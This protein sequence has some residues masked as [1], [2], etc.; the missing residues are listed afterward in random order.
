MKS[1]I[2]KLFLLIIAIGLL[3][4]GIDYLRITSGDIPIFNYSS[5]NE[6]NRIQTYYGLLYKAQRKITISE[7]EPLIN[8]NNIKFMLI[9]YKTLDVPKK[10]KNVEMEYT[11]K[12]TPIINCNEQSKLYY[13][14]KEIKIY[15]YCLQDIKIKKKKNTKELISYLEKNSDIIKDI[16]AKLAYSGTYKDN[17][18]LIFRP[19]NDN[20][21]N[22]DIT[23][24]ICNNENINDIYITPKGDLFQTDFCTAKDDE[25]KFL[26]EIVEETT[27]IEDN[28]TKEEEIFYEDEKYIYK[29]SEKKSDRI[30][31][32]VPENRGKSEV[33]M[34]I[35]DVL[36]NNI[37]TI[38]DLENKGLVF[39]KIE[40]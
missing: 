20:F 15:T 36:N 5:Y 27:N 17:K 12:T 40:K 1:T 18:T 25:I 14:N 24:Y 30:F 31:I 26:F 23:M 3:T 10:Y 29:F 16:E 35:K 39:D 22:E 34:A 9:Y 13:A 8:S 4:T 7:E 19:Y 28:E 11:I 38:T 21:T 6:D 33:K 32:V 37:L 2:T